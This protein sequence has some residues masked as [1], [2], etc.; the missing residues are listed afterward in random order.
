MFL[1]VAVAVAV[2]VVVVVIVVAVAVAVFGWSR[3]RPSSPVQAH[4]P[5]NAT[6]PLQTQTPTKKY[7]CHVATKD[8]CTV[9]EHTCPSF[10]KPR[11]V[12]WLLMRDSDDGNDDGN[13]DE[14]KEAKCTQL[15]NEDGCNQYTCYTPVFAT[16]EECEATC[17]V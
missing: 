8:T 6:V 3:K 4:S 5:S 7:R 11:A 2:V 14:E 15:I 12:G 17:L 1:S 10:S 13:D 16:K 9:T